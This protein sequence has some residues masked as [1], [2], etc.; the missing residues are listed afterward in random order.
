M[1]IGRRRKRGFYNTSKLAKLI[2]DIDDNV[3]SFI[4]NKYKSSNKI[5][6]DEDIVY[7]ASEGD[8]CKLDIFAP[9]LVVNT[10]M[11]VM[12]N[13][14]GGGWVTGDKKWRVAQGKIFADM[15]MK[16]INLNY[17][18]CP[19]YTYDKSIKHILTALKWIEDNAD[20]YN[21]DLDNVF[22]MGDSAGGQ[23]ACQICAVLHNKEFWSRL[24]LT[25]VNFKIK[26]ALLLCGAYDFE[27]LYNAPIAHDIISDMTGVEYELI[28]QYEYKDMLYTLPWIDEDFPDNVFIA[29]GKNDIFVGK[30]HIPLMKRLD[31]LGKKYDLYC[32]KFPGLH[33]FH[34]FYKMSE[35]KAMYVEVKK[36]L[37]DTVR[38]KKEVKA[39]ADSKVQKAKNKE[40]DK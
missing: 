7:S 35:S 28:D 26:G 22:I 38:G 37:M 8:I 39:I 11:P 6:V 17:G 5:L 3:K 33:C 19:K 20:E 27:E 4:T 16:V 25:P 2:F 23:I 24:G 14:H 36:Y 1:A 13:V 29:Y 10:K 30:H 40:E 34:L 12:I 21:M 18:L 31:E 32:G 15:G 9:E